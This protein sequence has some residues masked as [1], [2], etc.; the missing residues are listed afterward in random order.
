M[1]SED[2]RL[3]FILQKSKFCRFLK[4]FKEGNWPQIVVIVCF[5]TLAFFLGA[6]TYF[7]SRGAFLFISSYPS[8]L[9]S[10][11]FYIL[12]SWFF[13]IFVLTLGSSV[14]SALQV[15]FVQDDDHL[16]LSCPI[17]PQI[18]FES[19][20]L[21]LLIFSG[22]PAIVFGVPLLWAFKKTFDFSFLYFFLCFLAL[23]LAI[24]TSSLI[25]SILALIITSIAGRIGK[26]LINLLMVIGLP[27]LA[28]WVSRVLIP[29]YLVEAFQRLRLEQIDRFLKSLPIA[30][31]FF[32]STWAVN[33]IFYWTINRPLAIFNLRM[34]LI[35]LTG[36]T[37]IIC[38]LVNKEYFYSLAKARVGYFLAGPHDRPRPVLAKKSF[39]SIFRGLRGAFLEKDF[40]LFSRNQAEILQAGFIFFMILLY[41]LILSKVPL[42]N[43]K[44]V[45]PRLSTEKLVRMNFVFGGYILALLALRFVFPSLSV[46]GQA[47]WLVWSAPFSKREIFWQK[48]L[49]GWGFL[50][51]V[52]L[53]ISL[54][55]TLILKLKCSSFFAQFF[56]FLALSL[57]L[58]SINLGLGALFP[59]FK[60]KNLE[61]ISTSA[62][63]ILTTALSLFYI[64]IANQILPVNIVTYSLLSLPYLLLW[65]WL[66]SCGLAI[67]FSYLSLPKIEKYQF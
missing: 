6:A 22:W 15:F 31:N 24:L 52:G 39:P 5:L 12:L 37:L 55:S 51:L 66:I 7:F 46:E 62:G 11:L 67:F 44:E 32:P 26:R 57:G 17:R 27:L 48:L 60:E 33:F 65:L 9:E 59:N 49:T 28:W 8:F 16:L 54:L 29:P 50:S 20:L 2:L 30:A 42:A 36:L 64:F 23:I 45:L 18:I 47:G 3:F 21:D 43:L 56:I 19:R 53:L 38:W 34:M 41:F 63:G 40:L 13:L 61:K 35:V 58:T 1:I 14:V 4:I 25:A 10:M